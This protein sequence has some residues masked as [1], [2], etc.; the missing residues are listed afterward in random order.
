MTHATL[1]PDGYVSTGKIRYMKR[2]ED[3]KYMK[4]VSEHVW[5]KY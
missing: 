4:Q 5:N 3:L 2:Y 1:D